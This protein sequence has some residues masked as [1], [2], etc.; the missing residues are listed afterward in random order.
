MLAVRGVEQSAPAR[1]ESQLLAVPVV[2]GEAEQGTDKAGE[3]HPLD[4]SSKMSR[5]PECRGE[6]VYGNISSAIGVSSDKRLGVCKIG[7]ESPDGLCGIDGAK[8][9]G[10]GPVSEA[11]DGTAWPQLCSVLCF[12]QGFFGNRAAVSAHDFLPNLAQLEEAMLH[13]E[14]IPIGEP[15]L[16]SWP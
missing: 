5:D 6:L 8:S 1:K 14:V 16:C 15:P 9:E 12:D 3:V 7:C 2:W 11:K 10:G 4:G 13:L